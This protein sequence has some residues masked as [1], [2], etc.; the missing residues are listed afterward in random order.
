VPHRLAQ[1]EAD[2][3]GVRLKLVDA[4]SCREPVSTP[5][6]VR[7]RLSLENATGAG[8]LIAGAGSTAFW[9]S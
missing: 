7:G 5:Q 1:G 2:R 6:Q 3:R 4:F 8:S 9:P